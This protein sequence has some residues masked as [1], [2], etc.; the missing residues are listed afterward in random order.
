MTP[1][2]PVVERVRAARRR[3]V[4]ECDGDPH[5]IYEW[6]K[7]MEARYADRLVG[8]DDVKRPAEPAEKA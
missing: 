5:K 7:K 2:D 8:Y 3:I 6:A 4:E 1:D